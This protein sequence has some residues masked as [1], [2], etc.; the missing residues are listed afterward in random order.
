MYKTFFL[1]IGNLLS[2]PNIPLFYHV[3][4]HQF[5]D[6][7]LEITLDNDNAISFI[8]PLIFNFFY[9][10]AKIVQGFT[11]TLNISSASAK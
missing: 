11:P 6:L 10:Q 3:I 1:K 8:S 2:S 7:N 9:E 4:F 5:C